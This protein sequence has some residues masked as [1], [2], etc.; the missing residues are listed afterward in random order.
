[1]ST[2][3]YAGLADANEKQISFALRTDDRRKF[4]KSGIY[5]RPSEWTKSRALHTVEDV[6]SQLIGFRI[7]ALILPANSSCSDS[8]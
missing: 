3:N 8:R 6:R 5:R 4:V 1:V 7:H 2:W